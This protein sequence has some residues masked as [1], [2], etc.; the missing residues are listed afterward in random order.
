M[1]PSPI[2]APYLS[3]Y[4]VKPYRDLRNGA[5]AHVFSELP[6]NEEMLGKLLTSKA[7]PIR[8]AAVQ[9]CARRQLNGLIEAIRAG[10]NDS[11]AFVSMRR[12]GSEYD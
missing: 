12:A 7:A 2:S 9:E 3:A 8:A 5:L 4:R 6:L 10:L 1:S 11:D